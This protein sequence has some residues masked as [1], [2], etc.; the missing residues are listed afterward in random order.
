VT[1]RQNITAG[2]TPVGTKVEAKLTMATLVSGTVIPVGAVFSGEVMASSAK[3]PQDPSRLSI[4]MESVQWKNGAKPI[5]VYLTAWYYPLQLAEDGDRGDCQSVGGLGMNCP[6]GPGLPG[7]RFPPDALPPPPARLS[8]SR[9]AMKDVES[10]RDADG[11]IALS[12][13]HSNIKLDK[14]TTYVFATGDLAPEKNDE[15]STK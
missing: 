8:K 6:V 5:T 14:T 7:A 3:S 12:S 2:K 15:K 10:V 1:M 11:N 4:R 13:T 9:V